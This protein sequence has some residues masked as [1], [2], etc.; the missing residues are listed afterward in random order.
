MRLDKTG[1]V[2][3]EHRMTDADK[4]VIRAK[5]E[6]IAGPLEAKAIEGFTR[7]L[8]VSREKEWFNAWSRRCEES[9][10]AIEPTRVPLTAEIFASAGRHAIEVVTARA[11][12]TTE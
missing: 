1:K 10:A 9:L 5:V 11:V 7:C 3:M 6:E 4:D 12:R 2:F 8:A